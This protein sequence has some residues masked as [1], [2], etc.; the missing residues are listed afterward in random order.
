MKFN[1]KFFI[2]FLLVLMLCICINT[3]SASDTLDT[4][5]TS[6]DTVDLQGADAVDVSQDKLSASV[7][8]DVVDGN[9]GGDYTT[10]SDAVGA[11]NGDETISAENGENDDAIIG[12][13]ENIVTNETFYNY[14]DED[15]F[16]KDSVTANELV[17]KGNFSD[18]SMY[19]IL[20]R[21]MSVVG[22]NAVLNNMGFMI[23]SGNVKLNG[24]TLVANGS[25]GDLISVSESNVDLTNLNIAYIVDDEMANVISVK[26]RGTISNVN[27]LNNTI[28]FESHVSDDENYATAINLEDVEDV[29]VD[30][31]IITASLPGLYVETYDYT[32]FMMGLVYV[33]PIRIYE[34]SDVKFTNNNLDVQVNS[35]DASYPTIQA[36]YIVGSEDV[37]IKGNNVTMR[38]TLTPSGTAIYLYAVECGFSSGIS[39]IENK[40][41]ILT[42]GGKSGAGSAY[43]LQIATSDAEVIGNT[44]ICDSNG[45]NL[46]VYSPYGFGPAKDLV[47]KDNFIN[48]TGY[49]AGTS[50]YALI[51]G[52]EI[53]TGYATIYNNTIYSMNKAGVN[54]KYPVSAVSAVQYSASTLSFDVQDNEIYTNGKYAVDILYKV[55]NAIITGNYL[56]ANT[57][58]GD[59][60][61][62]IKSGTGNVIENNYPT[63]GIV[64]NDTFFDFFD[65]SGVLKDNKYY[66]GLT[67]EGAFSDLVD[68]IV[69]NNAFKVYGNNATLDNIA[70]KIQ[71]DDVELSGLTINANK[72][73]AD[74]NGAVIYATG[75]NIKIDDVVVNYTAPSDVEAIG[76]YADA[77]NNFALTN[78]EIVYVATNPGDK[79]N[80]GLEVRNSND[81]LIESN[82]IDATLPAV[83]VDFYSGA[84][85]IDQDLVLAVGVQ[86]GENIDFTSNIVNV[87]INGGVG[88]Y[89]TVD[90]VM[91]HSADNVLVNLNTITL[92]DTTTSDS[93]RYYYT[94]DLYSL[95]GVVEGNNIIVNTTAGIDRAGTA[96]PI[97]L[98]GPFTVVV[99]NN[100]L[101][102][103]S[104]GPIAG[105][106]ASNWAGAG[107]L[108][109]ED[110]VI[111][112]TGYAT[113]GNYAL[114]SGIE[115]ETDVLKAYNNIITVN[116]SADYDDA[117]QV[118]GISMVS[119]YVS[120]DVSAEI[121][122]NIIIVDG[123]YAVYYLKAINTN[124]TY[125]TLYAHDLAGDDSVLIADGE[126]NVVEKNQPPYHFTVIIDVNGAWVGNDNIVKMTIVN[127]E[128]A[129]GT[130]S[131]VFRINGANFTVSLV[132]GQANY[133]LP[134]DLLVL[135]ENEIVVD[136]V[137]NDTLLYRD[138]SSSAKFFVVNGV[139]TQDNYVAYFNQ[140][141]NGKLFDYIPEGATLD[142]QGSII[143]PDQANVVQMNVNK[144]VNIISS[145]KD[146]YVDLNTTA[147]SLL[148]ES[149][150]NSFAIT[151]G[152]SG[153]NVTGIYFHNTQMW[154]SN[155]HNVVLDNISVVVEDQKVGSGVGAT[156]I[157]DNSSYVVLKNSYLYT[158]N[159]GGSS[160]F[161]ISWADHCTIDNCTVKA[162]GN[163]GNLIYLNVYN[164]V[165][166]PSG[167]PLNNYN[168][169][170]NNR[171]YGKEGS[172]I[173]VALMVEGTN[174]LIIN[175]TLY[176]SS[177]STSFGGQ[178]PADNV[179]VG[180]VATEGG[181]LTAQANSIVYDND[182]A[183]TL[184]TG[185]GSVAYNNIVGG[186]FT[187]GTSATAYD[188]TIGGGLTTGG[189]DAI[190]EN[191]TIVGAVTINKVRTSFVGND[192]TGTVTVSANNNII[193]ENNITSTGNY[194]VDLGAKTGNTVTDNYLVAKYKGDVSV[195]YSNA[196]NVV[197]NN[198][199]LAPIAIVANDVWIGN[200]A[201][202]NVNIAGTTGT[203]TISV[204]G[205]NKTVDLVD[206][207]AT[208]EFASDD[209]VLGEN[210]V[211]ATYNG[212][213]YAVQTVN[214]TFNVLNGVVTQD[215]YL[216][217]FNQADNG[218]L[219]DYVPE[220]ATL[221]FQGSIINPDQAII[222]QMNINKPV[223]I[224]SSTKDAYIDL[225][226]TAGSLLGESPGNSFAVTYG[227]SGTNVTGIYFHNTQMWI[228][229]THNVVL[230]NISVVVEDQ[231]VGSGVGATTIRDNSSYV[232]LK[233]SYLYTRNN[234][235]STTF[236]MSWA[237]YCTIDNCT[238][239]AEG[240][241]GNLIYLNIF[242]IVGAPTG[243]PLNNYNTVSNNRI[244]G[245]EGSGISVGL[246]VEGTNNLIV[247]NTLYKSSISTSFGGQN[248][249]NNTYAGNVMTEGSG[250][251]AHPY[252]IIYGNNVTGA[253]STG[254]GSVVYDN[255]VGGKLTVGQD[256]IVYNNTVCAG[257]TTG[258]TNAVI[259]NN[260]IVGA[261]T[262]NKVGTIFV[263]NDV[264]GTV[265]VSANNNII[266][267]N[268][269]TSTGNYAVDLGSKTEN[270]VTDN[271]LVASFYKG[272]AA[273][274]YT[275]A[276]NVVENNLPVAP[277]E[278]VAETVW[279]GNNAVV[280]VTAVNTTGSV[281]IKVGDKSQT[282]DLVD[283]VATIE[284]SSE[285]LVA[286]ENTVFVNYN[287]PEYGSS[288][289]ED[290]LFVLDGVITNATY[291][292]YFDGSGNLVS[293]VPNGATLDFQGLFLGKYPVY[294]NKAV[295]VISSTDDA[296]F[297]AGAT[298]A[299]N[300]INSFNIVAGG[301]TTNITGLKFI[302]YCLYIKGASN[303]TVD[304]ISI[305]A[306]KR[307]VGSGTGFLSIH[308]GAYNTLIK[309]GY[310]EN[311]GTGSS[312]LV[313]GKGGAY[314]TFDH[315]V[316]NITG[317]SGNILS[318][319][320][321]VGSG[322]A[323]EHVAYTNNVLYN[324][325]PGS[326][327]CYAM[328]VSG[329][330]N[331]VE[332]N[333][334]YHNGSGILN[335]YGASSSG[336]VYRNNTL[337]GNTNF[338]PSA[339]SIVE[340][341]KIYATTNI[342]ANTIASGNTFTNVAIS[343]T[344]TTFANNTVSGT[345]TVSGN[346][347]V[348]QENNITATGDYAV[349]LKT[350]TGNTVTDNR[351]ISNI[352][353]GDACVNY[354]EGN[355]VKDNYRFVVEL[356]V[357]AEDINI[358]ETAVINISISNGATG[359]VQVIVDGKKYNA[360]I[361][362]GAASVEIPNLKVSQ[363]TVGVTYAGD[364]DFLPGKNSTTFT[365]SKV[366]S[367]A[368]IAI[369]DI[370]VGEDVNV[371]VTIEG[372][373]GEVTL[374]VDRQRI[375]L[376]LTDGVA[377]YTIESI[378]AGSHSITAI[379]M[380]D[381]SHEFAT[382]TTSFTVEKIDTAIDLDNVTVDYGTVIPIKF[383]IA[384]D[385][386]GNV[387]F[388][389][390]GEKFFMALEN[391][392]IDTEIK[393][394]ANG[395]YTLAVSY[396]G[397]DKYKACEE[398]IQIT[399]TGTDA[400]LTANASDIKV[401]EDAVI[402]I[403][404]NS[405]A[406]GAV[407]VIL[408]NEYPANVVD[409][410]ATVSISGLT[411][412][413]YT[414]TVRYA[415][416]K[417]FYADE[418]N[419][420]FT[421]SKKEL[422]ENSTNATVEIP[423]GTTSPEF[424]ITLPE[425]AI[426]NFTVTVDGENYTAEVI[427]GTATVKV[428]NLT[429]GDHNITTS[430][431]GDDK[432]DAFSTEET[433]KVPKASIPGGD[434][435]ISIE[436]PTDGK[437]STYS[438][439]L[440]ED[441]TGNLTVTVDGKEYTAKVEN[442]T[443]T[444]TVPELSEG[445]HNITVSYSGDAKYSSISKSTTV[446]TPA[447]TSNATSTSGSQAAKAKVATKI[448][449][450]KKKTYKAK[451]KVKKFKITL[452]TKAGKVIKKAKV[453]LK[454]KGKKVIKAKT[455]KK[456][457]ATFKIKKLTKKGK[458]KAVIK[459]AG[460]SSYKACSKKV[461]I[462]VK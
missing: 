200:N 138:S 239:K 14:F 240:N 266:K 60:A 89:P 364:E 25:L 196:N 249:S 296:L 144:P 440:P 123:K 149:P 202:V 182:I 438:I 460:N 342:A 297:D 254:K 177:I 447:K 142:F 190:I 36:L 351:L 245:K 318:A 397:D 140:D 370:T 461:T 78:S 383:V 336:N 83:P 69:F 373:T 416:D 103:I 102:A 42:T 81:V 44:I 96:Y 175:N 161:T 236:T 207:V 121:I 210:V 267:E 191:N 354:A 136:Y 70:V 327:F 128:G 346:N 229:N 50:E 337:Y 155:T 333:T 449:A 415:G 329:S 399:V 163:V 457:K 95:T 180:N 116:N 360:Q 431:S 293:L 104:K 268:N 270:T 154:I 277:I 17:F 135:G 129:V 305:V 313:L 252:S 304:G 24:L 300:N 355:V 4:N 62:Y 316:F 302:N 303:V 436:I 228:S 34:G 41:D 204:N 12:D 65:D 285:Y 361:N 211:V 269:I 39:F 179:Y 205:K 454:I 273:V 184:T 199:P 143:N 216:F 344:G 68:V 187:V 294:I 462:I 88:S 230:D 387:F 94:L 7:D 171:I 425:D 301:D 410:K 278:I 166:A 356:S 145:T 366:K 420:T 152:G 292:Y 435:A 113:T 429:V 455:N 388:D 298:Y 33:N 137:S 311:G 325:Q 453:T 350:T 418:V 405:E 402:E 213:E 331:L 243:V 334:I 412:G 367:D 381:A 345:V 358:G 107:T 437:S 326:A 400:G 48:V 2:C 173:S 127:T 75:S 164:I 386:T 260:T 341:N 71:A 283:G 380:G 79:H 428:E 347:N 446:N 35:F 353:E 272:D 247:N 379:Y 58:K 220:G 251:T 10:I 64:T 320:Q 132:D 160:T 167:V 248:P 291:K 233:N 219:F 409:G 51:S 257:L 54:D 1:K 174:N 105:I 444:V 413:T 131:A 407:V 406:T 395:N 414:V 312:L 281:T 290:V 178:K 314:A 110:N 186:K 339:N 37:L 365:V 308:T 46:G 227:G 108:I 258:G 28:Y 384:S 26:S 459:Y 114:V 59:E 165:G 443:A 151:Y 382:N 188:N 398:A 375:V 374:M 133:T 280:T 45:P 198:L 452:K 264:A 423:E 192:V 176:K 201:T 295:N 369:S 223:N 27:I 98:T 80:Y 307:G 377:N 91:M 101:T 401:G 335:Q 235:G 122:D 315:N 359:T 332:N 197:E 76:I 348:I 385:A 6:D 286:Q 195:K 31:N 189:T 441:A 390:N 18:V 118:Y 310:F 317:S 221:D 321:Y 246:M 274:K 208:A 162:E 119:S 73:F 40:F 209:L 458:F 157:R 16:L 63:V 238:V 87:K 256:A 319:N 426:G 288:T 170:S 183:G 456:G 324:N 237:S 56:A 340:N 232:V 141:D 328:T 130:G 159:N 84:S 97:Q 148:G 422:P 214:D 74:N 224:I 38:D 448:T 218:K 371:T 287:G 271:V 323:P 92:I 253:L 439:K 404:I 408:D 391:G 9:G 11:A 61:A 134:A 394:L 125:N 368:V 109:V 153:T 276:N 357:S 67:F 169:V 203:V 185:T 396:E 57:L 231:R 284:V 30:G 112:V 262:I 90:A 222:V 217:Y 450:K 442:G 225:N 378:K 433:M 172:G 32:Y 23:T 263:G 53:Q 146:A 126:N 255:L 241:V 376:P 86:G 5:L 343:G 13:G 49:A 282:V 150:G 445:A 242:N 106:Y 100:N 330:G 362:N 3:A 309:N 8:T 111:D 411:N 43:A 212:P 299:G 120:G 156:S 139:V 427:N 417:K 115:A 234:G 82:K 338:N 322:N 392:G 275:N 363:Y 349:D 372:A 432:Y 99:T 77:A 451:K 117:N 20:D 93:P 393:G 215:N 29:I 421:V 352:G 265:T 47:I 259:E 147:G 55:N 66:Y 72:E 52:I 261:V 389:L 430:Y 244:Y 181:S 22:E 289:V 19:V 194:A 424:T 419:V 306:N 15:G 168:T 279:T 85:G 21:P 158:R 206:G 403:E 124:V 434:D 193:K 226:T 250:L